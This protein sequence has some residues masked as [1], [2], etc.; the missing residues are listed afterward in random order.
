M[1]WTTGM[2]PGS[3]KAHMAAP[4]EKLAG[5]LS[6]LKALQESAHRVKCSATCQVSVLGMLFR[7]FF[8]GLDR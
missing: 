1:A 3:D 4:N 5:S 8:M 6:L 2:G 7:A